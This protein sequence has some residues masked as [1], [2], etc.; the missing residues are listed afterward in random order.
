MR[1]CVVGTNL[2]HLLVSLFLGWEVVPPEKNLDVQSTLYL[3]GENLD[4][5]EDIW[6]MHEAQLFWGSLFV[7]GSAKADS[8]SS[9]FWFNL[10]KCSHCVDCVNGGICSMYLT[11]C[12]R[13]CFDQGTDTGITIQ[14]RSAKISS[15]VNSLNKFILWYV[16]PPPGLF[17]LLGFSEVAPYIVQGTGQH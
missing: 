16:K 3:G 1:K 15:S 6:T 17:P 2:V 14:Y 5:V 12:S 9:W 11:L 4:L 13:L 7:L 8:C 10:A